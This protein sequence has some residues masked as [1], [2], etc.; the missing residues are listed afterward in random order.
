MIGRRSSDT[1]VAFFMSQYLGIQNYSMGTAYMTAYLRANGVNAVSV[2]GCT[3]DLLNFLEDLKKKGVRVFGIPAY[4]TAFSHLKMIAK[5][6][7]RILPEVLIVTGGPTAT[8]A[9][10]II[11]K[12]VPE[13]DVVVRGEGEEAV[14]EL[15]KYAEGGLNLDGVKGISFKDGDR[16]IR[17]GDR[18]L[19]GT[20][21]EKGSEL[22]I[23]PSPF[24][25]GI[26]TGLEPTAGLQ[27]SRGCA[28][29]CTF[30]SA[31]EMFRRKVRY[32]SIERVIEDLRI[33]DRNIGER[34]HPRIINFWDDNLCLDKKRI[35]R[36]CESIV[37]EDLKFNFNALIRP[38]LLDRELL[39]LMREAG[40]RWINFGLE[41]AVPRMLRY[42]KKVN[43]KSPDFKEEKNY[44][45]TV[46]RVVKDCKDL[47]ITPTVNVIFGTPHEKFEDALGSLK[48]V[49][50]LGLEKYFYNFF[51]VFAGSEVHRNP[52][53]FDVKIRE[54]GS[55]LPFDH[56]Y[57]YDTGKIP[58]L[59]HGFPADN[60]LSF[61]ESF[62][63]AIFEW[64][65]VNS[66]FFKWGGPHIILEDRRKIDD[67]LLEWLKRTQ[68]FFSRIIL[69]YDRAIPSLKEKRAIEDLLSKNIILSNFSDCFLVVERAAAGGT[70]DVAH[71]RLKTGI[72]DNPPSF[73]P[74][75]YFSYPFKEAEKSRRSSGG[76][77]VVFLNVDSRK[78]AGLFL[79]EMRVGD[80]T[81]NPVIEKMIEK[82]ILLAC[83][84]RFSG[85]KCPALLIKKIHVRKNGDLASCEHGC[86][87]GRIGEP[88]EALKKRVAEISSAVEKERGC[89]GC[90]AEAYCP[91]CLFT[92]PFTAEEYCSFMRSSG[93]LPKLLQF[94]CMLHKNRLKT[95]FSGYI[96]PRS[97]L[98]PYFDREAAI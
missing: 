32:H 69:K 39:L 55:V 88:R 23:L 22:D 78:D 14:Y 17:T 98:E 75:N 10:D 35:Q 36:L 93:R 6:A 68:G 52:E 64:W 28:F 95:D 70:E 85:H 44:L 29:Q 82:E 92:A 83:S 58:V 66:P 47:G 4:D 16:I 74:S 56:E 21:Q 19:I 50:E 13:I 40:I 7:R 53:K 60:T 43:G 41:S 42:M 45:E 51:T 31:P 18:P 94:L 59:P 30:C 27:T 67:D 80:E 46:R 48:M 76:R 89:A 33:I 73:F 79:K 87:I 11:F 34:A 71:Y 15:Y 24:G 49:E 61:L 1:V 26:L 86:C 5:E 37:N 77:R 3:R 84:C 90:P 96:K 12:H 65:D 2:S 57:P 62:E 63:S 54:S 38:D 81:G 25:T 20:G 91:R 9:D 97:S 8:F 72:N